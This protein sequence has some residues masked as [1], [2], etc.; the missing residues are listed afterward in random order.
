[1]TVVVSLMSVLE[2]GLPPLGGSAAP[3]KTLV[4][5]LMKVLFPHPES[6][7]KPITTVFSAE[8]AIS[9][10]LLLLLLLLLVF[11]LLL[12]NKTCCFWLNPK[13]DFVGVEI[14]HEELR[15]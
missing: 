14:E 10:L 7:A 4:N 5:L 3:P 12:K 8:H 11:I 1:M 2:S 9:L 6:A 15:G 13:W